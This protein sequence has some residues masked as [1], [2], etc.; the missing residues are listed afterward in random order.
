MY[1]NPVVVDLD[2][3]ALGFLPVLIDL[4]TQYHDRDP[5]NPADEI[6]QVTAHPIVNA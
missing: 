3:H 4:I 1:G 6:E 5:E 2:L